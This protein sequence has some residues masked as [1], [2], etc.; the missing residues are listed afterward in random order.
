MLGQTYTWLSA[1]KSPGTIPA[2]LAILPD[3]FVYQQKMANKRD[4]VLVVQ[5]FRARQETDQD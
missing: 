1:V 2:W 3:K 5:A 4:D